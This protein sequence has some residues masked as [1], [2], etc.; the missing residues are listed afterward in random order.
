MGGEER[1]VREWECECVRVSAW[2]FVRASVSNIPVS[3]RS[4]MFLFSE[5]Q[6]NFTYFK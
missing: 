5:E 3:K 4:F 1:S 6:T 2:W